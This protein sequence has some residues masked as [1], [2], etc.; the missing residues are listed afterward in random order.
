MRAYLALVGLATA[1]FF[2]PNGGPASALEIP[3]DGSGTPPFGTNANSW[4]NVN[5]WAPVGSPFSVHRVPIDGDTATIDMVGSAVV[6]LNADTAPIDGVILRGGMALDTNG[7]TL[8]VDELGIAVTEVVG[9]GSLIVLQQTANSASALDTDQLTIRN[10]ALVESAGGSLV[11][12]D[13]RVF[14]SGNLTLIDANNSA[15]FQGD[16]TVQDSGQVR[17]EIDASK[18]LFFAA[19]ST[20]TVDTDGSFTVRRAAPVR[21]A[22]GQHW[23]IA[24]RGT[25]F[26]ESSEFTI[27]DGSI[28]SVTVTG[29]NTRMLLG[30]STIPTPLVIGH[31]T[32]GSGHLRVADMAEFESDL[33]GTTVRSTGLI[34][35]DGGNFIAHGPILVDGGAISHVSG[36]FG[37]DVGA[38]FTVSNGGIALLTGLR[39]I[40]G[41]A[42]YR[43]NSSGELTNNGTLQVG[44]AQGAGILDVDGLG[45]ELNVNGSLRIGDS[46]GQQGTVALTNQAAASVLGLSIASPPSESG[47]F[48]GSLGISGGA[49]LEVDG[50]EVSIGRGLAVASGSGN[51]TIGSSSIVTQ[52][53]S[54]STI[55]GSSVGPTGS[56]QL[57]GGGQYASGTGLVDIRTTGTLNIVGD[58]SGQGVFTANGLMNVVGTVNIDRQG[59]PLSAGGVLYVK[60]G[61]QTNGGSLNLN[62]G[63]VIADSISV[64]SGNFNF[65]GGVLGVEAFTGD[66]LN[67][68]GLL[69]P[70]QT[71]DGGGIGQTD[72]VGN[73]IQG[74]QGAL[75]I[76]LGGFIPGVDF[77]FVAASG[78]VIFDGTLEL[79]LV[80][81]FNPAGS[82]VFAVLA[83][84]GLNGAFGNIDN[85]GRLDTL[86]GGGSFVVNYGFG[87]AFDPDQLVLSN[88]EL[89]IDVDTEPDGDVDGTDFL[90]LQRIS[91]SLIPQWEAS[92]GTPSATASR[93]VPETCNL[94]WVAVAVGAYLPVR[95]KAA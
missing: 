4:Q 87:S 74:P 8:R 54:G 71:V 89:N 80:G 48:N 42:H 55:L 45:S 13:T 29:M 81:G 53:G 84:G 14:D 86:D 76:E 11:A 82:D 85:G 78:N 59:S 83:S 30:G 5:N 70:G 66:L 23:Q 92:Y 51:L 44:A 3:W 62:A 15:T 32:F 43:V 63:V 61:L 77:D 16:V 33:P 17:L 65:A 37:H 22:A 2:A 58:E 36:A 7:F 35:I 6:E 57:S 52:S 9:A 10:H 26:V 18:T 73:Y 91:P 49:S 34:E 50:G 40:T 95:R 41:S 79:S 69:S 25:A 94:F 27:G 20:V 19:D 39:A 47:T 72:V 90:T 46:P 12:G 56:F 38:N 28:G 60:A 1:S 67:Q 24:E 21:V 68:G 31:P 88:F 64:N 93:A 75:Q